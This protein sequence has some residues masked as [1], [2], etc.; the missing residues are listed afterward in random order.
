MSRLH[1]LLKDEDVKYLQRDSWGNDKRS[2]VLLK[3]C[4]EANLIVEI[5]Y[6]VGGEQYRQPIHLSLEEVLADDW[7][8]F[9]LE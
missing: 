4:V 7:T 6:E 8:V 2:T 5:V 9:E 3:F 1:E